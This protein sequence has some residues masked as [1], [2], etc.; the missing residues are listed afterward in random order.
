[1]EEEN[2]KIKP[3]SKL[4]SLKIFLIGLIIFLV[5]FI[6]WL[7]QVNSKWGFFEGIAFVITIIGIILLLI[8]VFFSSVKIILKIIIS[9][10]ILLPLL[11]M[12]PDLSAIPLTKLAY[13]TRNK[14]MC[15][16]MPVILDRQFK[17]GVCIKSIALSTNDIVECKKLGSF[18][19]DDYAM[20][21]GDEKI[22]DLLSD[23]GVGEFWVGSD[24]NYYIPIYYIPPNGS[25][26]RC[27][28]QIAELKKDLNIC[29]YIRDINTERWQG[30]TNDC[31][32]RLLTLKL[33]SCDNIENNKEL[34]DICYEEMRIIESEK[35][36]P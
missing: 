15:N 21:M 2:Q 25:R 1:M 17:K 34:S 33:D 36:R 30:T 18:C 12:V 13:L 27:Y 9:L 19:I 3:P 35:S 14:A 29:G 5:G 31:V 32:S 22:C 4:K 11:Y 7:D 10:I 8:G 16:L 6:F 20:L 23:P 28:R 24:W 26:N